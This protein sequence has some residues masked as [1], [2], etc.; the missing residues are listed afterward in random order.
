MASLRD[1]VAYSPHDTDLQMRAIK[2]EYVETFRLR[3]ADLADYL[4]LPADP[5]AVSSDLLSKYTNE[6]YNNYL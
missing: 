6:V 2:D 1:Q 5:E 3:L 4:D